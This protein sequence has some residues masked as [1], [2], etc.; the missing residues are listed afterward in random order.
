M[1]TFLALVR[2]GNFRAAAVERSLTQGA[3][4]QHLKKLESLLGAPLVVRTQRGCVPTPEGERLL[5]HAESLLRVNG[6]ALASVRR[7]SVA[8]GASSNIGIYLL[9]PYIKAFIDDAQAG[10]EVDLQIHR[11]P[12]VAGKL[13]RGEID[14][15]VMEW[16]DQRAGCTAA[17]WRREELV[18]IVPP[19]HAWAGM[20]AVPAELLRDAPMLGGESG[21]G[22]GRLLVHYFGDLAD[23]MKTRM[24]LGS[25]E[26]VKQWVRAGLGI[27]LVL[28]GT[29]ERERQDGT[30]CAIPLAG[31]PLRKTLYVV[32][33]DTQPPHSPGRRFAQRLLA[34][35]VD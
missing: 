15:A 16:W 9:Q 17:L 27:S 8:V 24:N 2:S 3:V 23:G 21:T 34:A 12:L 7:P 14:V 26:A 1:A 6:R 22:T 13:E 32:W 25:T 29:V 19:D 4:S 31:E 11:N 28:A 20:S 5:P 33:R 18:V 35:G 30:L 10:C